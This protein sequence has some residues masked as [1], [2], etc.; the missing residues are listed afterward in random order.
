MILF[1]GS[2]GLT[3]GMSRENHISSN[4]GRCGFWPQH[5]WA[6]GFSKCSAFQSLALIS[7]GLP[8]IPGKPVLW[9]LLLSP[10]ITC[11]FT[12]LINCGFYRAETKLYSSL[13]V[14][15]G[16]TSCLMN[17]YW[18]EK[19]LLQHR[20]DQQLWC[21]GSC[22]LCL[23]SVEKECVGTSREE[24]V[25]GPPTWRLPMQQAL[26]SVQGK[27]QSLPTRPSSPRGGGRQFS[28]TYTTCQEG[29]L[30]EDPLGH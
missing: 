21:S 1:Q 28:N 22:D 26:N 16:L 6:Q 29:P 23:R 14:S 15:R 11:V 2:T 25:S 17:E 18:I 19:C 9:Y 7:L 27:K 8:S 12:S 20:S 3:S 30:Q 10:V 24:V 4:E 13:K 5:R